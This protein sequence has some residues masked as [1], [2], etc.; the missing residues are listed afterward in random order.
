MPTLS[1]TTYSPGVYRL[2]AGQRK[3]IE[4]FIA[5]NLTDDTIFL[6]SGFASS[7]ADHELNLALSTERAD[8][9]VNFLVEL[10]VPNDKVL[11]RAFGE[12]FFSGNI[13]D[14][15]VSQSVTIEAISPA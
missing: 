7:S 2:T 8:A 4:Q 3:L 13:P 12:R 5:K 15:Q 10:T 11:Q 6:V 1:L 14:F 9:V